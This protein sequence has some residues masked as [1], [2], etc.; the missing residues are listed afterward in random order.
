MS[1]VEKYSQKLEKISARDFFQ[2]VY[3][4]P[5]FDID[6]KKYASFIHYLMIVKAGDKQM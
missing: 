2:L 4:N 1:K 6:G 3:F 5:Y